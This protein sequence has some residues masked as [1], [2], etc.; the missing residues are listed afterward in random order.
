LYTYT[1]HLLPLSL[2]ISFPSISDGTYV[3]LGGQHIAAAVDR[4]RQIQIEQGYTLKDYLQHVKADVVRFDVDVHTRELIAGR[5]NQL[6]HN[7]VALSLSQQVELLLKEM[8]SQSDE[9]LRAVVLQ[10][11][12]K[13]GLR[14]TQTSD[15]CYRSLITAKL[16]VHVVFTCRPFRRRGV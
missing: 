2:T 7:T 4:V 12:E 13:A 10:A 14:N 15:V 11:V 9:D 8:T 3:V 1:C 5:H 6:Q 16:P